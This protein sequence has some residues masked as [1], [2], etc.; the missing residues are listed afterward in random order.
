MNLAKANGSA[1]TASRW[2]PCTSTSII[3]IWRGS[4]LPDRGSWTLEPCGA[5]LAS[6]MSLWGTFH[7]HLAALRDL[8][9]AGVADIVATGDL[10]P[11]NDPT[12]RHKCHMFSSA[13][14]VSLLERHGFAIEAVSASNALTTNL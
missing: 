6:V 12:S 4:S 14:L 13:E 9:L 1:L 11:E 3:T 7:R 10:T 2:A 5:L 8:P